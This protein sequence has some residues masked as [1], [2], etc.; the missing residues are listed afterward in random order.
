MRDL[1]RFKRRN[2]ALKD[3]TEAVI[4]SVSVIDLV[5]ALQLVLRLLNPMVYAPRFRLKTGDFSRR[6]DAAA[7]SVQ[8][9]GMFLG[10][11]SS[12]DDFIMVCWSVIASSIL[13]C[14]NRLE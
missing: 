11:R 1:L 7:L 12:L 13:S 6:P 4:P 8:V 5:I 9:K 14:L 10:S 2:S 3:A